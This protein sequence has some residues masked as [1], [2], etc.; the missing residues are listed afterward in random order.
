MAKDGERG[1][2]VFRTD[3]PSSHIS[4]SDAA[5]RPVGTFGAARY[6][7]TIALQMKGIEPHDAFAL[8]L[9]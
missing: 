7:L 4:Y 2:V 5:S 8:A 6:W 3:N 9:R 1:T